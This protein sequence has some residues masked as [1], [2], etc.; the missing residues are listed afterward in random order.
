MAQAPQGGPK[1]AQILREELRGQSSRVQE[2]VVTVVEFPPG[3]V[4]PWHMHP[5]AHELAYGLEG[6]LTIEIEASGTKTIKAGDTGV[7][8]ADVPHTVRNESTTATA[9]LLVVH[10]RSDKD[11][12]MRVD[13]R[14]G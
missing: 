5:G 3:A 1:A 13:V 11:K 12:P 6:Q 14:K 4:A 8:A 10:S 9:K 7:I 2:T